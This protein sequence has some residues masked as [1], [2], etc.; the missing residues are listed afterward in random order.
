MTKLHVAYQGDLRCA[1]THE[2]GYTFLT[3]APADNFGKGE[4][5]SPTDMIGGALASCI[6]TTMAIVARQQYGF[7][8][9]EARADVE[10][11]MSDGRPRRIVGIEIA[12]KFALPADHPQRAILEKLIDRCPVHHALHPDIVVSVTTEWGVSFS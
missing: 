7:E 8:L 5:I 1:I 11:I 6:V 4:A 12:L 9:G 2:S 3:D 10:K